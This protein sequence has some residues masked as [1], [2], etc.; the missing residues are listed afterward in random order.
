MT[1]SIGTA[2]DETAAVAKRAGRPLF[3]IA[4]LLIS[5]P[6]AIL[7]AI[8]PAAGPGRLPGPGLWLLF[9][10][11]LFAASLIGAVAISHLA[12]RPGAGAGE[13]LRIALARLPSLAGAALLVA[14]GGLLLALPLV[15][16][17]AALA[18]YAVSSPPI[19]LG[20]GLL[21]LAWA[22]AVVFYW[23]RLML[24][25]PAAAAEAI[26]PVALVR[27][28]W[29][30]TRGHFRKLA[31]LLVLAA[32]VALVTM[33]A[34]VAVGGILITLAAGRPEPGSA[35]MLLVL[36]LSALPQAAI[37][38]LFTALLARIYAQLTS[39]S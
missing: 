20:L 35:V 36:A 23:V 15:V 6:A 13:A 24:M 30:L 31:G 11:V 8:V 27:R 2:W 5:L 16:L 9:V 25:T 32:V 37:S 19:A 1:L 3:A 34:V 17:V 7:Q 38:G 39:G 4:F 22:L 10:P 29:R 26:G 33:A 12:L 18:A 14:L 21:G 28:S